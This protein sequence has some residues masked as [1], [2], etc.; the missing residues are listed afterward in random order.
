MIKIEKDDNLTLIQ[1]TVSDFCDSMGYCE[2][3]IPFHI[4]GIKPPPNIETIQGT[5]A[6]EKEEE[7]EKENFEFKPI[8][9]EEL[10]DMTRNVE[11]P[12]E[13]IF[14]RFI[15]PIKVGDSKINV[16]LHG[17]AD[18]VFRKGQ[19]LFV[20]DDKFPT[21][22]DK[23]DERFEPYDDQKLQAL[24]YLHSRFTNDG[25]FNPDDWFE[26]PH[27]EKAWIIQIRDKKHDNKPYRIFQGIHN[28]KSES[29]FKTSLERFALLTL[30]LEERNHHNIA[31]KCNPCRFFDQCEFRLEN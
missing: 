16:L 8:T 13:D 11:F 1:S 18:K 17:R 25:S 4:E 7:F 15:Y 5:K 6:H 21:N 14:T 12:R 30:G 9:A 31:A 22:L 26:I 19:T 29:F 10:T 23:Y 27:K 24:T 20:Q 2:H 28:E 3:K